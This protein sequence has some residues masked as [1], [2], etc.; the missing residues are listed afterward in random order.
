MNTKI[1]NKFLIKLSELKLYFLCTIKIINRQNV[2]L[3]VEEFLN[4]DYNNC[5]NL[6]IFF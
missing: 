4:P 5:Y 3:I 6:Y 2:C 1:K